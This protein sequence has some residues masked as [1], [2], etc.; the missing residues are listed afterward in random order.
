MKGKGRFTV[1]GRG[2]EH[3]ADSAELGLSF[4]INLASRASREHVEATFYVRSPEGEVTGRADSF[5]DGSVSIFGE[6]QLQAVA[7]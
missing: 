6:R 5:A 4:A 7:A 3:S 2:F 1:T